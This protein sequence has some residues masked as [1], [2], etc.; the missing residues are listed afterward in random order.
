MKRDKPD[1]SQ[2]RES[3]DWFEGWKIYRDDQRVPLREPVFIEGRDKDGKSFV[4]EAF[5]ENVSRK[6]LCVDMG[7]DLKLGTVLQVC[8]PYDGFRSQA[9]VASVRP[10]TS[11]PGRFLIGLNFVKPNRDWIIH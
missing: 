9:C 4:E 8:A 10:S 6:G 7:C 5:T 3:L 2:A 11:R 1:P